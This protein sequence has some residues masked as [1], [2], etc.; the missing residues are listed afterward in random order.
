MKKKLFIFLLLTQVLTAASGPIDPLLDF[1]QLPTDLP[2]AE[3]VLETQKLWTQRGKERWEFDR[4]YEEL[5]EKLWPIFDE[6]GLLGDKIP[7]KKEYDYALVL[8][9][10]HKTVEKRVRYLESLLDSGIAFKEIVF[11]GGDRPLLD[12]EKEATGLKNESELMEWIYQ[13][14]NLPKEIPVS[15]VKA[16][17]KMRAGIWRRPQTQDTVKAWLETT[18]KPGSSLAI[19]SQPHVH[20]QGAIIDY[21]L[22]VGFTCETVGP[23]VTG[24]PSTPVVLDAIAME[25]F[26]RNSR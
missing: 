26:W 22:P 17:M 24:D 25:L 7:Q 4:R 20:C 6:M 5:N 19:S 2:P 15:F 12:S 18:P 21:F 11:L 3:L 8:G 9:A 10:L 14:S 16:P 23:K 1:M 13:R